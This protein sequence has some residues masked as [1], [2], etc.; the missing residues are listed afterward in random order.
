MSLLFIPSFFLFCYSSSLLLSF[1]IS[2]LMIGSR[3]ASCQTKSH[4]VTRHWTQCERCTW[5]AS[6]VKYSFNITFFLS[7]YHLFK[8]L[9]SSS[10]SLNIIRWGSLS[11]LCFIHPRVGFPRHSPLRTAQMETSM[12]SSEMT[13]ASINLPHP[14]HPPPLP[15]SPHPLQ[16]IR[17]N[18]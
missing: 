14:P 13:G 11:S 8:F 5:P 6:P 16:C 3:N 4:E 9:F 7:F 10:S 2:P 12:T 1:C 17:F 18:L 15:P